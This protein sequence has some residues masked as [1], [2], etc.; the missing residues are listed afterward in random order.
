MDFAGN[1]LWFIFGGG[2]FAWLGWVL[3]GALLCCTI[4]GIPF[5]IAAFR[6]ARF[7]AFPFGKE[8]IDVRLLGERRRTG[9]GL[10]NVLWVVLAGLW[11]AIGHILAG[12]TCFLAFFLVLPIFFGL[13]HFKLAGVSFAPLGKKP[14]PRDMALEARRRA[15][16]GELDRRARR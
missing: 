14:V 8:L 11:L 10:A 3:L 13:A 5:G 4:V 6:I 15:A 9:T 1:V 12:I 16:A 2:I 7:A